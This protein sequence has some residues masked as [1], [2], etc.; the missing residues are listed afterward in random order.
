MKY[1]FMSFS[2][3]TLT[4]EKM[5]ALAEKHGYDGIEPRLDAK[6]AHG[7]EVAATEVER[8]RIREEAEASRVEIACLATSCQYADPSKL[9]DMVAQTHER[10]DLAGDLG[11]LRLRVFGG[12]FPEEVTR[13]QAVENVVKGLSAVAD[14]AGERNVFI[15]METHDAWC[16]PDDV[17]Q[18]MKQVNHPNIA[19]NWDFMHPTRMEFASV[20]DSFE[21][22]K[23]WIKHVHFHDGAQEDGKLLLKPIGEGSIDHR[24]A[25]EKLMKMGYDGYLS[26]E[27]INW[28]LPYDDHLPQELATM[29]TYERGVQE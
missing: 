5:L 12:Q 28:D 1:A 7:V 6:H 16:N 9:D 25:V 24:T 3:P 11:V 14:H 27:W 29:K 23:P 8:S 15:C 22:L 21:T 18:V 10:I 13:E 4:L 2:T 19:V 26:G 17:A 20:A